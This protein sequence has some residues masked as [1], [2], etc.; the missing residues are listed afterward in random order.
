[1][2]KLIIYNAKRLLPFSLA[3]ALIS[4]TIGLMTVLFTSIYYFDDPNDGY[5]YRGEF[6]TC[7]LSV[8][9]PMA[10]FAIMMPLFI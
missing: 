10:I 2:K 3:A 8:L 9:I 6:N 1:M 7:L 4:M 5:F